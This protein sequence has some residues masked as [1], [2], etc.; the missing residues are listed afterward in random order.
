MPLDKNL[1]Q[2]LIVSEKTFVRKER[3][4]ECFFRLYCEEV[5]IT[6]DQRGEAATKIEPDII[7]TKVAKSTKLEIEM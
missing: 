5:F 3:K 4:K 7:T 1:F 2:L 6:E